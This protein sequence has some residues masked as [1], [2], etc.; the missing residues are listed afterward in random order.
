M[1]KQRFNFVF[2]MNDPNHA[3][4]YAEFISWP[5]G[6]RGEYII[7]SIL[8]QIDSASLYKTVLDA[9]GEALDAR[10]AT[11]LPQATA[12]PVKAAPPKVENGISAAQMDF[13]MAMSG[14]PSNT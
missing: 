13:L 10:G 2:N 11:V 5:A 6:K 7:Q 3:R 4:A 12:S 9:V 1:P 8:K 14:T